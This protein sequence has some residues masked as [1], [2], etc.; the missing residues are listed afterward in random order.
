M[1]WT[2]GSVKSLAFFADLNWESI[3]TPFAEPTSDDEK[4][5]AFGDAD[6]AHCPGQELMIPAAHIQIR[7]LT[8]M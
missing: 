8:S 2:N 1:F 5:L 4:L 7:M 3:N 6:E